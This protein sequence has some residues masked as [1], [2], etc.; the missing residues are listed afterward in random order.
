MKK[1]KIYIYGKHAVAEAL[2]SSPRA[3]TKI[4][5]GRGFSDPFIEKAIAENR[6]SVSELKPATATRVPGNSPAQKIIGVVSPST[7]VQESDEFLK[8][9]KVTPETLLVFLDRLHDPMNVGAVIRS[10][11]ALGASGVLI[12]TRGQA[13]I[14]GSV[15]KA[16]AGVAFRIP[17]VSVGSASKTFRDLKTSGFTIYGLAMKG[18]RKI[19]EEE[20]ARPT[21][22][23]IGNEGNG[24]S[25][26]T[27]SFC[28]TRLSI[29]MR[30]GVESLNAAVSAGIAIHAWS[31]R[32]PQIFNKK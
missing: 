5:L 10:A 30:A 1:E 20:F 12:P 28:D 32:H 21:V 14:T 2:A 11:S 25:K 6:I 29:P 4:F 26:E 19:W 16:S 3:V 7:L 13:P 31:V 9:L 8:S 22:L 27:F 17:L 18:A 23:V 24:I 15:V